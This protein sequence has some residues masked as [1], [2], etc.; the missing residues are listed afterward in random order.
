MATSIRSSRKSSVRAV[1]NQKLKECE[2]KHVKCKYQW[3]I[4]QNKY[5]NSCNDASYLKPMWHGFVQYGDLLRHLNK[6]IFHCVYFHV[7][8]I[9]CTHMHTIDT[10]ATTD[11]HQLAV[12]CNRSIIISLLRQNDFAT[13]WHNSG[14]YCIVCLL[15]AAA[16]VRHGC[17]INKNAP[18]LLTH[19]MLE[20]E[21]SGFGGEYHAWWCSG[22]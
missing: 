16:K 20:T 8:E 15:E 10:A 12:V 7:C 1:F 14:H 4:L 18:H 22:S 6:N 19:L 9:Q 11:S 5:G 13:F 2:V 3:D 17:I 21:C